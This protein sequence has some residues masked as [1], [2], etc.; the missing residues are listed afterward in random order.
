[1]LTINLELFLLKILA[2]FKSI[3]YLYKADGNLPVFKDTASP[4]IFFNSSES[5]TI[6]ATIR[7]R[8]CQKIYIVIKT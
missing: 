5:N 3:A 8:Y 4:F 7:Q 2:Y 1:V 6:A